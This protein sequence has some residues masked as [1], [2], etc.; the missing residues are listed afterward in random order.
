MP[1]APTHYVVNYSGGASSWAAARVLLDHD[2]GP[3]DR[4]TL[5]FADT[6]IEDRDTYAFLE[7]GAANLGIPV[8]RI[9]DG[10]TPWQV[11]RDR[12]ML[13]NTRVDLCSRILKREILT[14]WMVDNAPD[15]VVVLGLDW[16]EIDRFERFAGRS[17]HRALAPLIDH[18]IDKATVH[19]MVADAGLPRQRLYDMGLPHAN[20]GG[21]CVKMGHTGFQR[22]LQQFPERF[23]EWEREEQGLRDFLGRDIAILRDRRR[24]RTVPFTLAALRERA[25][26]QPSLIPA[27][28]WGACGCAVD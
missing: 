7:A 24:G 25:E 15:G 10:R 14:E 2:A 12:R 19:R 27:H 11:F 9:A 17:E 6:L 13:G 26:K 21:G 20:C 18:G 4:V 5:L 1:D 16:M 28:D 23:A 22:L 3:D 8:T